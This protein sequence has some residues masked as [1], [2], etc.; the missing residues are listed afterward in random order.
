M[1]YLGL[2]LC[3]LYIEKFDTYFAQ[4]NFTNVFLICIFIN[5]VWKHCL[6][7]T[8][9]INLYITNLLYTLNIFM[10]KVMLL[11]IELCI[12]QH[13][14]RFCNI[15]FSFANCLHISF[16]IWNDLTCLFKWQY[17]CYYYI[18]VIYR[19]VN[20]YIYLSSSLRRCEVIVDI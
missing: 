2:S 9:T 16:T 4:L 19:E 10:Y 5:N 14:K 8:V 7:Y 1:E 20:Y 11:Y 18:I 6:L 13:L 12:Y 15:Y 3:I 17:Y